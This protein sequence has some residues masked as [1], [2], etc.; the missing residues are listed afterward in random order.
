MAEPTSPINGMR[1]SAAAET[2]ALY[3][4]TPITIQVE[5][6]LFKVP[7]VGFIQNSPVFRDMFSIPQPTEGSTSTAEGLSDTNPVKLPV[8]KGDFRRLLEVIYP[9][10]I[11][12][13]PSMPKEGWIAVLRLAKMWEMSKIR[14]LAIARLSAIGMGSVEKIVLAKEFH[15]PQWLRSGYQELVD[16]TE[17]LS[18]EDCDKID[19]PSAIRI[20]R[21]REC[22][23]RDAN[24]QSRHNGW[25]SWLQ[26]MRSIRRTHP[27]SVFLILHWFRNCD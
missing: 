26:R 17:M 5:D 21:M 18:L 8:N 14:A 10:N 15:V 12:P 13:D 20:F 22:K 7:R 23:L 24:N 19:Y 1:S 2:D 4:L 3:Y 27:S 6:T 16:Q 25:R 11:P 9:L